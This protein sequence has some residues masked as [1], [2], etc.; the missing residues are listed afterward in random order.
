[1]VQVR[2]PPFSRVLVA[3]LTGSVVVAWAAGGL[4]SMS[5]SGAG[6]RRGPAT[7]SATRLA[8]AAPDTR[9]FRVY[10]RSPVL[11]RVGEPVDVPVDVVCATEDGDQCPVSVGVRSQVGSEPL[12]SIS[13]T[14]V[15]QDRFDLSA[16][17]SRA[18]PSGLVKFSIRATDG[19]G[20]SSRWVTLA[21]T[22][23]FGSM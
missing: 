12:G 17:A 9:S 10:Y 13:V 22:P 5:G 2:R 21:T 11:V 14:G 6:L 20:R 15:A 19:M 7:L 8:A 4:R 18:G 1:M 16:A 23:R 3:A